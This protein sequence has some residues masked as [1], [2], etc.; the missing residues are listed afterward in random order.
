MR[1]PYW[2]LL[3]LRIRTPRL[4]LRVPSD[5]DLIELARLAAQG[6]HPE[7]STPFTIHW[8]D[9]PSP[10]L[11]RSLMQWHWRARAEWSPVR[12][13]LG[14]GVLEEGRMVGT[15]DVYAE[16]FP[17]LRTVETGS[18]LGREHQ[19]RGI[20]K[21]MRAAVLDLAFAGL[22]AIIA[23]SGAFADNAASLAVSR[24]MGYVI[25]G[26]DLTLRRGTASRHLRLRLERDEWQRR[27]RDDIV[28]EGLEPC[29]PILGA[30]S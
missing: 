26:E 15:Q 3:D 21:E 18:W 2:P 30:I 10:E 1:H 8:T 12:W 19:G 7:S 13:R 28:I 9:Q 25:D 24:A 29:L 20:G 4:E 11:E 23:R 22:A 16:D 27:R 5:D 17:I 14:F 6:V